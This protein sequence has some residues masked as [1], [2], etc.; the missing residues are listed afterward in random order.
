MKQIFD[1]VWQDGRKLFTKNFVP[2][3]KVYGEQLVKKGKDEFRSWDHTRSKAAAAIA[4][5]LK[6]FLLKEGQKI[7]Y[8]GASS[9]TT[10]SHVSDIVG[11]N[12]IVYAVE[13]SERS[14]RDLNILAEH[15]Q[16]IVPILANA[17]TP[18]DYSWVEPCDILYQDVA[19][20]DQ[21]EI[22]I[23]NAEKFL[24]RDGFALLAIKSRSIDVTKE[25]KDV[26]KEELE[27]LKKVFE[28]LEKMELDPFEKDH[29]FV[30]LKIK[31][32]GGV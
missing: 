17:K 2:G 27:K 25:P 9:G 11:E 19:T 6:T 3:K 13:I 32:K 8:L 12:G 14:M 31:N 15:R 20:E 23:R 26:Y 24:K 4:K 18:E 29:L 10:V 30:V 28:I 16:N 5:G 22:L 1:G 21:S 7:L